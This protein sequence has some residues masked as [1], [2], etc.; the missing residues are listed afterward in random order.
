MIWSEV[1]ITTTPEAEEAIT[2]AFYSAGAGGVAIESTQD[3]ND[4][5]GDPLVGYVDEALL[6]RPKNTSLIRGYFPVDEASEEKIQEILLK[7]AQLPEYG[8]N[9][10]SGELQIVE[11][12]DEDWANNWKKYFV[13]THVT[14]DIVVVPSWENYKPKSEEKII[15][16][17][18]GMAFGTG[19]HE[20]TQLCAKLLEKY[21][22]PKELLIDVGTGTGILSIIAAKIGIDEI[23][24]T[25]FDPIALK[26]AEENFEKNKVSEF[27]KT[28]EADLLSGVEIDR[29]PEIIIANIL[30]EPI[31]RLAPQAQELLADDGIFI[32]SGIINDALPEVVDALEE[33]SFQI[34]EIEYM[35]EWA[36]IA[37]R[38]L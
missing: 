25:D 20:T 8:L 17:E 5:W 11:I 7:I 33:N 38:K 12:Q 9:P 21:A 3:I 15:F 24:A 30:P 14:D 27:I 19:T 10:G 28:Y 32:V 23:I 37:A 6:N 1:Q 13:A 16:M 36:A 2:E 26:V 4:L 34:I 22:E 31:K 29:K 18:P 35:G